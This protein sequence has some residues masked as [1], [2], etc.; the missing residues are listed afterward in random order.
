MTGGAFLLGVALAAAAVQ[1]EVRFSAAG[2]K[3]VTAALQARLSASGLGYADLVDPFIG[4]EFTAHTTPAATCPFGFVQAGPDTGGASWDHCSGYRNTDTNCYGFSQTH[5][6]GTG[7]TDLGD[8]LVKPFA[9]DELSATNSSPLVKAGETARPGYYAV[10]LAD[11]GVR[12]EIAATPHG[13]V[14]RFTAGEKP[15]RLLID[16]E[17]QLTVPFHKYRRWHGEIAKVG[18]RSLTAWRET[19][20]WA[21]RET[22]LY[23]EFDRPIASLKRLKGDDPAAVVGRAVAD[24]GLKG[25]ETLVMKLSLSKTGAAGAK[26]NFEAELRNVDFQAAARAAEASWNEFLSRVEAKGTR[27]ELVTFYTALYHL[28]FQPHNIADAGERPCYSTLSLWDTFRAAHPLYT[29]LV[30]ERV[31]DFVETCVAHQEKDGYLPIWTLWGWETQCMIGTHSVPVIVDAIEKGLTKVDPKRAYRAIR[32]SLREKHEK[33]WKEEWDL[34]DRYG[35]YPSDKCCESVSR[36]LECAYDD[37]CAAQLALKVGEKEEAAF[38][39]RRAESWRKV[40]DA[41]TGFMRGRKADGSWVEPFDPRFF[42]WGVD[43]TEANAW[44]YTWHVLHDIPGLIAAMGGREQFA[45]KLDQLFAEPFVRM[46]DNIED[47]SGL[48]GQYAHGNEPSHHVAYLYQFVGAG[49]K[50]AERVR[51]ICEKFYTSARDGL[52]GN[53]DC[54]QMSAWYVMS[55]MGFYPVNPCGGDY[56]IGAPQLKELTVKV[57][58]RTLHIVAKNLSK[59]NKYVKSVTFNGH[60]VEGF[61]LRHADLAQGGELVFEMH[62]GEFCGA[63]PQSDH[64]YGR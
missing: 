18:E 59:E 41:K 13:A 36:T 24:F 27:E 51:E 9:G 53:E 40:F 20:G 42:K 35:Y 29:I 60:R 25:G 14:Y 64:I 52:C 8:F 44:Q 7:S 6:S 32:A 45:A 34:L 57:G 26:R 63:C 17:W 46:G 19:S 62:N 22:Y 58:E 37:W 54:G 39:A 1:A 2:D 3:P 30:P 23:A 10:T 50:T 5:L 55:V 16:G 61:I 33:R 12:V 56:V 15:F 38:F 47:I 31:P 11:S 49:E 48:I 4:T 28:A 21:L 43:F